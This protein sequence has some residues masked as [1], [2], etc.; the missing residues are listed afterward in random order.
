MI[1][2]DKNRRYIVFQPP[3]IRPYYPPYILGFFK[4]YFDRYDIEHIEE[5]LNLDFWKEVFKTVFIDIGLDNKGDVQNRQYVQAIEVLKSNSIMNKEMSDRV[6]LK[7]YHHCQKINR[8][9]IDFR[10]TPGNVEI[11]LPPTQDGF[12]S[13]VK[14]K[15]KNVFLHFLQNKL[16]NLSISNEDSILFTVMDMPQFFATLSIKDFL[17]D[18]FGLIPTFIGGPYIDRYGLALKEMEHFAPIKNSLCVPEVN[19]CSLP[20]SPMDTVARF[21]KSDLDRYLFPYRR[22]PAM[23]KRFCEYG[24]CKFCN[25]D[26]I[27][28]HNYP[29]ADFM[30]VLQEINGAVENESDVLIL[31]DEELSPLSLQKISSYL[32]EKS[33]KMSWDGN[34]R[35]TKFLENYQHC[36]IIANSG[37]KKLFLG[38]ETHSR[39]I[40]KMMSKR[41]PLDESLIL[42]NLHNAGISTQIS[43]LFGY[44]GEKYD[45]CLKTIEFVYENAVFID[46][47]ESNFFCDTRFSRISREN[48]VFDNL[49]FPQNL[50][51]SQTRDLQL[52][53]KILSEIESFHEWINLE[54]KHASYWNVLEKSIGR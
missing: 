25:N 53:D 45:D 49:P 12:F 38:L 52:D 19:Y 29:E 23:V 7:L 1:S 22:T 54:N 14:S 43:L 9:F 6:F 13:L 21:E 16:S 47:I 17:E 2:F 31:I 46:I 10:V 34:T 33:I 8:C 39:R 28:Q 15:E 51:M 11:I 35:F 26:I 4:G 36:E 42:R 27:A 40:L 50:M 37:C 3:P 41:E 44:P 24:K 18:H 48:K 20:Y 30:K 32:L 5:D